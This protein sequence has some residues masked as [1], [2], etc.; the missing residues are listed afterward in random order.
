MPRPR[1][2]KGRA[3]EV[4]ARLAEEYPGAECALVHDSPSQLL[5][6][7]I[8]SAQC[9]DE[10]VNSVTPHLF[11]RYPTPERL[12]AAEPGDVEGLIRPTGF[13]RAKTRS[14]IGMASALDQRYG[15]E[16]PSTTED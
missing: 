12:A 6:A 14:L 15:G 9:T 10:R 16:G 2:I 5:A 1:T 11:A 4:A 13:F 7:T 8:L 3:R